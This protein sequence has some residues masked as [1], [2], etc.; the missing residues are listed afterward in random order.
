MI[1]TK[2]IDSATGKHFTD[3]EASVK[4]TLQYKMA[5][6]PVSIDYANKVDNISKMKAAFSAV[7][8]VTQSGDEE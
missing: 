6:H 3:F 7:T 4:Q 5:N 2:T 8:N 1:D